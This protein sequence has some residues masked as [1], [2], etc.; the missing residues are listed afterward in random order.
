MLSKLERISR[1]DP[2]FLR[3]GE[4]QGFPDSQIFFREA[5]QKTISHFQ[6]C[7]FFLIESLNKK[8]GTSHFSQTHFY[9]KPAKI[10]DGPSDK[11]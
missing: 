3:K 9:R 5:E 7:T 6:E 8:S 1:A 4:V 11:V 10:S 2:V